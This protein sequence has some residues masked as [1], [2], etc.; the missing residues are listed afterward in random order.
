MLLCEKCLTE[1]TVATLEECEEVPG[2]TTEAGCGEDWEVTGLPGYT[3]EK[4]TQIEKEIFSIT[5][6]VIFHPPGL[7]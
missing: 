2:D 7:A 3:G 6:R 4:E 1:A 5:K